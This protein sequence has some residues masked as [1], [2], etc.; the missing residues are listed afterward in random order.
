[1]NVP[2]C[3]D[4]AKRKCK[5]QTKPTQVLVQLL[6]LYPLVCCHEVLTVQQQTRLGLIQKRVFIF[7]LQSYK[8]STSVLKMV[9]KY[10]CII[11]QWS[12]TLKK[13]S[14]KHSHKCQLCIKIQS[15][16]QTMTADLCAKSKN[17]ASQLTSRQYLSSAIC[18]SAFLLCDEKPKNFCFPLSGNLKEKYS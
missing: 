11:I 2:R 17:E 3:D 9:Y 15:S 6:V 12:S 14:L 8:L 7:Y 13:K 18:S 1:M 4:P 16:R 10:P 5:G